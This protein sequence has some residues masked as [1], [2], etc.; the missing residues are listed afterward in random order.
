MRPAVHRSGLAAENLLPVKETLHQAGS[1][2]RLSSAAALPNDS[3]L[4]AE[5]PLTS[6]PR[7]WVMSSTSRQENNWHG[8]APAA[9]IIR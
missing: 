3:Q 4:L 8:W 7:R 5:A 2:G 1:A 9:S 6:A